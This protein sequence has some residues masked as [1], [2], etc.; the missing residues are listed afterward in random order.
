MIPRG[1]KGRLTFMVAVAAFFAIAALTIGFNLL[2]RANLEQDADRVLEARATAALQGVEVERGRVAAPEAPDGGT[3]D[4]GVWIYAAQTPIEKPP[5]GE[6]A[7]QLADSM[8]ASQSPTFAELQ[9]EDLRLH[10]VP[11]LRDGSRIGT[12]V[13]SLSIEPYERSANRALVASALFALA[14][15]LLIVVLTRIV[16]NR[17]LKPVASMTAE[18]AQWSEHDLGNR[19][20]LGP[21]HDELTQLAATFD[22][23]LAR[24][25]A[26]LRREQRVTAEISH[27][28]RTPLAAIAAEAELAL[29]RPRADARYREALGGIERRARQ[30]AEIVETLMAAARSP[31]L[32]SDETA[33]AGEAA[34]RAIEGLELGEGTAPIAVEVEA[35]EDVR[36]QASL[37]AAS[38]VLSPLLENA[39]RYGAPPISVSIGS[40]NGSV[41]YEVR[42][43]GPG[44]PEAE[45][46]HVFEPG[47]RGVAAT[48][49]E[50][51][52]AGLGL[53]LSRRLARTLGGNVVA[54]GSG[55]GARVR[56]T[57]PRAPG[58]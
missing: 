34:R 9:Q 18:A 52:G 39:C 32:L 37:A 47:V 6:A 13:A 42:D 19:F 29:R 8:I 23:L 48:S 31:T 55:H 51:A 7:N 36:V 30:L 45:L 22:S 15:L 33:A 26:N 44:I 12:V 1:L 40:E 21:P 41:S 35:G 10:S 58:P 14:M 16:V 38:Q 56:V 49:K 27:E 54:V 17:A 43:R 50:E 3:T 4:S 53:A 5:L 20:D 11:V 57:L 25:E 46:N 28:L 2:L 24:L